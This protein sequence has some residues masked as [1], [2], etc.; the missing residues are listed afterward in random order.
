MSELGVRDIYLVYMTDDD[1]KMFIL[2]GLPIVDQYGRPW[3]LLDEFDADGLPPVERRLDADCIGKP[4]QT[5]SG[6]LIYFKDAATAEAAA[7]TMI[8]KQIIS[9]QN[10]V[11]HLQDSIGR[12]ESISVNFKRIKGRYFDNDFDWI[13]GSMPNT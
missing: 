10:E 7:S 8:V 11:Q 12:L 2:S 6:I 1:A 3:Y 4:I 13:F 9:K 5:E